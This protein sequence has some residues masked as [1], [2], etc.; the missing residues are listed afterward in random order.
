MTALLSRLWSLV[1]GGNHKN[2][3]DEDD[4]FLV[5]ATVKKAKL[6]PVVQWMPEPLYYPEPLGSAQFN[7]FCYYYRR[8][9]LPGACIYNP[10]SGTGNT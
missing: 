10:S 4:D 3:N 9:E 1:Q 5:K 7:A 2:S 6:C 8:T